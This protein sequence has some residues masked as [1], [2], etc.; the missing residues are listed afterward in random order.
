MVHGRSGTKAVSRFDVSA[1]ASHVAA[2]ILDFRAEDFISKRELAAYA[3][4]A[5]LGIAAAREAWEDAKPSGLDRERVG[6]CIGSAVGAI[7]R[8]VTD[9]VTFFEHGLARVHP[10]FPLQ[11]PG[12]LPSQVAIELGLHGLAVPTSSACTASADAIGLG[13]L[14]IQS[15]MLDAVLAGGSDAPLFP[16]LFAAFDRLGALSRLNDDPAT[17]SRP[18]SADRAGFVMGEGA[19][20]V[21][22]E[23]EEVARNRGARI[24]AELAGFGAT[25]DAF[26]HLAP[27]HEG[28]QGARAVQLALSHAGLT[29]VDI[30]YVNAHGTSTAKN[31]AT[32]TVILKSALGRRALEIPVSSSKSMLG[33]LIGASAAVELIVATLAMRHR[34]VPPTINFTT[35]DPDCDL[36]YVTDGARRDSSIRAALSTS[37]GFGSRNAALIVRDAA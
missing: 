23:A 2:E 26:H 3:R 19:G 25:C 29:P 30:D 31:D 22:L 9:G 33:H 16:L 1:C 11:Y 34:I 21:M 37:F 6:V 36:D 5:H 14:Q 28:A 24:Y 10:M 8:T 13:M 20:V 32:E 7:D 27:E 4:F 18:F 17:A 12:T 35:P 15:G